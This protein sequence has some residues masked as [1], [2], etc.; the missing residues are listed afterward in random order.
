MTNILIIRNRLAALTQ[1]I[2][3]SQTFKID[4][5][6][7]LQN[8]RNLNLKSCLKLTRQRDR[9]ND[10]TT[11]WSNQINNSINEN[12]SD[13]IIKLF[14]KEADEQNNDFKNKRICY[15]C[16]EKRHITSK[17]FK[18]KQKSFQIN[19]IENFRQIFQTNIEKASSIRFIIEIFDESKN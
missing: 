15:N 19:I 12:R 16:G 11:N 18:L 7:K 10:T 8:D 17:C 1:R 9:K 14:L 2:K 4:F 6:N 13:E 3:N 5:E